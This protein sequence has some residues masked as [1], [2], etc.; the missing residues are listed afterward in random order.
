MK[1]TSPK[2]RFRWKGCDDGVSRLVHIIGKHCTSRSWLKYDEVAKG[3]KIDKRALQTHSELIKAM[4]AE[5]ENL[6]WSQVDLYKIFKKIY[7][8]QNVF[9]LEA[10]ETEDWCQTMAKRMRVMLRHASQALSKEKAPKWIQALDLDDSAGKDGNSGPQACHATISATSDYY[11]GYDSDLQVAWRQRSDG[12]GPRDVSGNVFVKD[13]NSD[14][15]DNCWARFSNGIEV[16]LVGL[17]VADHKNRPIG[18]ARTRAPRQAAYFRDR[19]V[20]TGELITVVKKSWKDRPPIISLQ[21]GGAQKCQVALSYFSDQD[22]GGQ[23]MALIAKQFSE[24]SINAHELYTVRDQ[25]LAAE[26]RA[27]VKPMKKPAG[28]CDHEEPAAKKIRPTDEKIS[29]DVLDT[30][31]TSSSAP[32]AIKKDDDEDPSDQET[33]DQE[34]GSEDQ[35]ETQD[36]RRGARGPG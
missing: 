34:D 30:P 29:D 21:V 22:E 8:G 13:G 2:R 11:H 7:E 15:L 35:Y 4:R 3:S 33:Q 20:N 32:K 27:K 23:F 36:Q 1:A 16:E 18:H 26:G 10:D 5:Q 19:H 9:V 14:D 24:G 17:T 31:T 25:K 6:S 12:K 28:I